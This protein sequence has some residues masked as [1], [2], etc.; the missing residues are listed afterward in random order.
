MSKVTSRPCCCI[1]AHL[2]TALKRMGRDCQHG[3]H[4][5]L[6][7]ASKYRHRPIN[8]VPIFFRFRFNRYLLKRNRQQVKLLHQANY[9]YHR[10]LTY[11][12]QRLSKDCN[13]QSGYIT[14]KNYVGERLCQQKR[15]V[16]HCVFNVQ[17][18]WVRP[19]VYRR[20]V[21]CLSKMC[22]V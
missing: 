8:R 6:G 18:G 9:R 12:C 14:D 7:K 13:H 4:S 5:T 2:E 21:S 20:T 15:R 1:V 22:I 19:T 3:V 11:I 10:F 16:N 17:T